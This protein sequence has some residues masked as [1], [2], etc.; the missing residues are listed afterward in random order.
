MKPS[1]PILNIDELLFALKNCQF[2]KDRG[3]LLSDTLPVINDINCKKA[4]EIAMC[5]PYNETRKQ[6][7]IRMLNNISDR[8]NINCVVDTLEFEV[9]REEVYLNIK[10]QKDGKLNNQEQQQT[11]NQLLDQGLQAKLQ[12]QSKK[13]QTNQNQQQTQPLQFGS[14]QN[15][16][17]NQPFNQG[18]NQFTQPFQFG[19]QQ[20]QPMNQPFNQQQTP[21]FQFGSQQKQFFSGQQFGQ[22]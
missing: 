6:A 5:F 10:N 20:N 2:D 18:Q 16:P 17:M 7:I 4:K 8:N 1:F 3:T 13:Q 14:Q 9:D 19:T 15:Q 22:K 11:Q 12:C 21:P